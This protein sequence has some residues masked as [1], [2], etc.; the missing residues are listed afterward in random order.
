MALGNPCALSSALVA[1]AAAGFW[2]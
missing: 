2:G 1:L